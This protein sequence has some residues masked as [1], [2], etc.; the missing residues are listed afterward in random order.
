MNRPRLPALALA[1]ALISTAAGAA[2]APQPLTPQPSP[3]TLKDGL[4]VRYYLSR[5]DHVDQLAAFIGSQPG[6][7]GAPLPNLDAVMGPGNVL[8]TT[9]GDFVG[10]R[11]SGLIAF[12][13]PGTYS[14]QVTSNDGVRLILGGV[15][16]FEDPEPHPDSVSPP[17]AVEIT[18]PGFYP[19]DILYYEKKGTATLKLEWQPPGTDAFVVV[20]PSAFRHLP[21]G[22]AP[23][24][25]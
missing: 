18:S 14:L 10:A 11:I 1:L 23:P 21:A 3:Q 19:L 22:A 20:P 13:R 6:K 15:M 24:T 8:G 7:E 4:A 17:L 5:F 16:L 25:K 9:S 2:S 12:E